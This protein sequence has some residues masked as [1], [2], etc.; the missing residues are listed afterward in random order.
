MAA[1]LASFM[2]VL[3]A[4]MGDKTQL[5]TISL[6]VEYKNALNVLMG[7]TLAMVV[8]DAIGI[9]VGIVMRKHIPEKS[10]KWISAIIFVL[11][12]L[13]GVYKALSIRMNAIFTWSIIIFIGIVTIYIAK[14]LLKREVNVEFC[15]TKKGRA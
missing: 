14:Y 5:A 2:F 7:T 8:A 13:S 10:I 4:E 11:F 12:G 6:A 3:L 9:S 15:K 1:F